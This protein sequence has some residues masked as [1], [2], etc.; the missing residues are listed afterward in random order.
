VSTLLH[1]TVHMFLYNL[2]NVLVQVANKMGL[3]NSCVTWCVQQDVEAC[4][5]TNSLLNYSSA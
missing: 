2:L 3:K 5:R 1:A 4:V